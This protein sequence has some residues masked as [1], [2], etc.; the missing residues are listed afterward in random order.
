MLLLRFPQEWSRV[1]I[2]SQKLP[3]SLEKCRAS[4]MAA[5]TDFR[6]S[7]KGKAFC[8]F[9]W[10]C[11]HFCCNSVSSDIYKMFKTALCN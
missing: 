2:F 8:F 10:A 9:L 3:E 1:R 6:G 7:E 5:F 11:S 4:P